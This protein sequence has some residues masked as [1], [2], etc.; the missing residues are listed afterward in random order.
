MI[1]YNFDIE[2]VKTEEFSKG[3]A[4]SRLID[5]SNRNST[6]SEID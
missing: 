6:D 3:D 1:G 4:L 2:Y 5:E